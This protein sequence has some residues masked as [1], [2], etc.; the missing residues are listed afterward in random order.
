MK[1]S[2]FD[3]EYE[4]WTYRYAK[5]DSSDRWNVIYPKSIIRP[6]AFYKYYALSPTS[7]DALTNLYVYATHPNQFNDYFDCYEGLL[8]FK[9]TDEG[10]LR[11]LYGSLFDAFVEQYGGCSALRK[12]TPSIYKVLFYSHAGL[13]SLSPR[14]DNP[15]LWAYYAN[16]EG[17]CVEWDVA[18][19]PFLTYGPFP[20]HYV[21]EL[22]SADVHNLQAASLMQTNVKSKSWQGEDEWRLIVSNPSGWDFN[23]FDDK[24]IEQKQYSTGDTHCRKMRY[25]ISAVRSV[26]LGMRFLIHRDVACYSVAPGEQEVVLLNEQDVL[27][28]RILDFLVGMPFKQYIMVADGNRYGF[29]EVSIFKLEKRRYRLFCHS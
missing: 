22:R 5:S 3:M 29:V 7:V 25:P 26:T 13:V 20:V 28:E 6:N 14:R 18:Q 2:Y 1:Q 10:L 9:R 21:D 17:F 11:S 15:V 19:F 23:T 8:N 27:R 24:G 16:N 12:H 4:G